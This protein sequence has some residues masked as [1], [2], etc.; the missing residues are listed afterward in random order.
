M[1]FCPYGRY[2]ISAEI[3]ITIYI[4]NDLWMNK[5]IDSNPAFIERLMINL[6]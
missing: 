3:P 4:N 1:W 5:V 2:G 6:F